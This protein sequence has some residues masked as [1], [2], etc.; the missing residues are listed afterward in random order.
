[1]Q[2]EYISIGE[3]AKRAGVN[4]SYI[5]KVLGEKLSPYLQ[6]VDGKKKLNVKGLELFNVYQVDT[7]ETDKETLKDLV[8][9][10][11]EQQET[12]KAELSIKNEQITALSNANT[13]QLQ[14]IDQQQK[15][16]AL[17]EAKRIE[18]KPET[19]ESLLNRAKFSTEAEYSHYLLKLIP[20]IGMFSSRKDRQELEKVLE[21]M[22]EY[23][24]SLIYRD[25]GAKRAID[26][27]RA[28]DFD[29]REKDLEEAKKETEEFKRMTQEAMKE[30]W[31]VMQEERAER[32]NNMD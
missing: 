28:V 22:S 32:L 9:I 12:L 7:E 11:K 6:E 14:L 2:D 29:Q 31:N 20:I 24:R 3:F 5:Y 25:K 21:M 13:Q 27:I 15:L 17:S 18:A 19:E 4:R 16:Q 23:E 8:S 26:H 30:A 10:L 1:M